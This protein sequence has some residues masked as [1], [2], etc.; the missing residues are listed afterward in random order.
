MNEDHDS[1]REPE[2]HYEPDIAEVHRALTSTA[3]RVRTSEP[4]QRNE[5]LS[6]C[7]FSLGALGAQGLLNEETAYRVLLDA[8]RV[9]MMQDKEFAATFRPGWLS[10]YNAQKTLD[11]AGDGQQRQ[12]DYLAEAA[13]V[14]AEAA[15][16]LCKREASNADSDLPDDVRRTAVK[17]RLEI[18][19]AYERLGALQRGIAPQG[20]H[21]STR[22][23]R[24]LAAQYPEMRSR[25]LG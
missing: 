16:A 23:T 12:D 25:H 17:E 6:G 7:A 2:V 24:E 1:D 21:G 5:I 20:Y 9:A 13:R 15:R 10:G 8:A 14:L 22:L 4:G 3:L 19:A 11:A 18:A